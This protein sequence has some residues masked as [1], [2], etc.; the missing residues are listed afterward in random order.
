MI[1]LGVECNI[2]KEDQE[3]PLFQRDKIMMMVE[4]QLE[5]HKPT[6]TLTLV[7]L[8]IML[9]AEWDQD[10]KRKATAKNGNFLH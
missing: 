7:C 2:L 10:F 4:C 9:L 6:T 5:F 1:V 8:H 3:K